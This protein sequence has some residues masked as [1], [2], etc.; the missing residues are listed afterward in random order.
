MLVQFVHCFYLLCAFFVS[1]VFQVYV[2]EYMI[3]FPVDEATVS[4]GGKIGKT[5]LIDEIIR[6]VC[7]GV[8][9]PTKYNR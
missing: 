6:L 4:V 5:V 2:Y 9:G 1:C 8:L 3:D 7:T